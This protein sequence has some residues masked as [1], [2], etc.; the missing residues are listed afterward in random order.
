MRILRV[1]LGLLL[2]LAGLLA[3]L[4]G[5]AAALYVGTDDTVDTGPHT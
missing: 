5:T 2:A 1:V 4:A 3:M